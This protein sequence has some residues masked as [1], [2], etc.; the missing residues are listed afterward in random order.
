M[1]N[2]TFTNRRLV[3]AIAPSFPVQT[4]FGNGFEPSIITLRHPQNE[5]QTVSIVRT[6][7]EIRD[8]SGEYLLVRKITSRIAQFTFSYDATA[9]TVAGWL[10][11]GFGVAAAPTGTPQNETQVLKTTNTAGSPK[12]A[13]DFEGLSETSAAIP[14]DSTAA[15]V[16]AILERMR[17]IKSGNLNITGTTLNSVGGL[18][19]EFVGKLAKANLP[20]FVPSENGATGGATTVTAGTNGANKL[21]AITRMISEIPVKFSIISGFDGATGGAKL[22]KNLIVG[23]V[24]VTGTRRGKVVITVTAYGSANYEVLP[25]YVM[26][27]CVNVDPIMVADCRMKIAGAYVADDLREFSYT[28]GIGFDPNDPDNFPADDIDIGELEKGDRTSIFTA[29]LLGNDTTPLVQTIE[30]AP[31]GYKD[32]VEL[33]IGQPGERVSIYATDTQLELDDQAISFVGTKN[34]SAFNLTATPTPDNITGIVDR[35]EYHGA[36]ATQFLLDA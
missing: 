18:T 4:G 31:D 29:Q 27:V 35:V 20:L 9:K 33:H 2:Q 3:L 32:D 30:N 10:A 17:P 36:F 14:F 16:K 11:Y 22:Y 13:F 21:H 25:S 34:K 19:V 5:P 26:P 6:K 23:S 28:Y 7:D 24:A 12:F 1:A 15:E 8:C